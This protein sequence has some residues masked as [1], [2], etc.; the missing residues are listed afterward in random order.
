MRQEATRFEQAV[1][2]R[3]EASA[4]R[5]SKRCIDRLDGRRQRDH[6]L[7]QRGSYVYAAYGGERPLY[8][9]ET[10]EYVKKRFTGHGKGAHR[11]LPWYPQMTHVRFLRLDEEDVAYR[12]LVEAA[13]V[14]ALRPSHNPYTRHPQS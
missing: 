1:L 8:V 10:G 9:G 12:R 7:V 3:F 13:L 4:V 2:R 14:R 11:N 5:A 6:P